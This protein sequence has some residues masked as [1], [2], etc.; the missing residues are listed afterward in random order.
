MH[1]GV[2]YWIFY[3]ALEPWVRRFIRTL[4]GRRSA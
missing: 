1:P 4:A 3:L 2:S